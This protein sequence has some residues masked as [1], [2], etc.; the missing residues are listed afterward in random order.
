MSDFFGPFANLFKQNKKIKKYGV[1]IIL[2]SLALVISIVSVS[3]FLKGNE[4]IEEEPIFDLKN[5]SS[6]SSDIYVDI[7]G[8]VKKPDMYKI[9]SGTRLKNVLDLAGG[10][11]DDADIEFFHRNFNLA[12][13]IADQAKIYIPSIAEINNSLFVEN[14]QVLTSFSQVESSDKSQKDTT[15]KPVKINI[16]NASADELDTLPGVGPVTV[17]KIIRNRPFGAL[18]D[19]TDKNIIN[20]NIFENIKNMIEI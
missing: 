11:S 15:I 14:K 9:L 5:N 2:I 1:E 18:L 17:D 8:S 12:M 3:V 10:L 19:L 16:N 13:I 6:N 4:V 20:K 7:E